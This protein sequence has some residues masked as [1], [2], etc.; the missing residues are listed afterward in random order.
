MSEP[1]PYSE[2]GV[3]HQ[4]VYK[5]QVVLVPLGEQLVRKRNDYKALLLEDL[6]KL[7]DRR[8]FRFEGWTEPCS[9]N[10]CREPAA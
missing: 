9:S 3:L 6:R 10:T 2:N 4:D 5:R 1:V 8:Y 7:T